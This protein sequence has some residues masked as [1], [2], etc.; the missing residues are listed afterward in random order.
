M[1]S[2]EILFQVLPATQ[3]GRIMQMLGLFLKF[4]IWF[5]GQQQ[6]NFVSDSR[7]SNTIL[8]EH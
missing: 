8:I 3:N 4:A 2:L 7:Q 1:L 6:K 5:I